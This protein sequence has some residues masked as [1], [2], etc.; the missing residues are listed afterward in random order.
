M[1]P[2]VNWGLPNIYTFMYVYISISIHI[3]IE[4]EGVVAEGRE[5]GVSNVYKIIGGKNHFKAVS[6]KIRVGLDDHS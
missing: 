6:S 2:W 3:Y 4:R 5:K 1:W